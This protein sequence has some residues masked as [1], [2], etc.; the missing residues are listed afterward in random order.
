MAL[1][2]ATRGSA[3]EAFAQYAIRDCEEY[4]RQARN[5]GLD[6][7]AYLFDLARLEARQF[8]DNKDECHAVAVAVEQSLAS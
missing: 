4:A 8:A 6:T 1:A 7:L 5:L 2:A 3:R